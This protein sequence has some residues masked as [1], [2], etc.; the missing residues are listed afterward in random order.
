MCKTGVLY[1]NFMMTLLLLLLLFVNLYCSSFLFFQ[2]Y[3]CVCYNN[4]I[5]TETIVILS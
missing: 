1:I 5:Q 2:T 4:L 3:L